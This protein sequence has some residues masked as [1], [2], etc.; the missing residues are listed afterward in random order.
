MSSSEPTPRVP[1][2]EE[3]AALAEAVSRLGPRTMTGSQLL[4]RARVESEVADL[5]WRALGFPDVPADE[6]AFT[7]GIS[8]VP[9]P[10][11]T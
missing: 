9:L 2:P 10:A 4:E 1:G 3:A 5:L 7:A 6:P 11:W 8:P